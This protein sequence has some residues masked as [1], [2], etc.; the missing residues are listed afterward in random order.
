MWF[1]S[2]HTTLLNDVN[3]LSQTCYPTS[4]K[5]DTDNSTEATG[6]ARLLFTGVGG[7][8]ACADLPP[9][10]NLTKATTLITIFALWDVVVKK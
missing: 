8:L 9:R 1:F 4:T 10:S 7:R 2:T 6:Q 3:G 5:T